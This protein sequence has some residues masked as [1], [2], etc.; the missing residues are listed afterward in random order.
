MMK[1][2]LLSMALLSLFAAGAQAEPMP[3]AASELETISGGFVTIDTDVITQINLNVGVL[4]GVAVAISF[5]DEANAIVENFNF[6]WQLND[7]D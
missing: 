2:M 5:G 7:V 3:L 6:S 1:R 4:T